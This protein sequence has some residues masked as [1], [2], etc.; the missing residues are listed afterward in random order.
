MHYVFVRRIIYVDAFDDFFN[1]IQ[2]IERANRNELFTIC[3]TLLTNNWNVNW[4][5]NFENDFI[6]IDR[7]VMTR[8]FECWNCLRRQLISY[9]NEKFDVV[10]SFFVDVS[11]NFACNV[12]VVEIVI[13]NST[14]FVVDNIVILFRAMFNSKSNVVNNFFE[15]NV[16][17]N[18]SFMSIDIRNVINEIFDD[19]DTMFVFDRFFNNDEFF[20]N[21][22]SID[23]ERIEIYDVVVKFARNEIMNREQKFDLY[24]QRI[25]RW[26]QICVSC[27][28]DRDEM[29]KK[30]HEH[31]LQSRHRKILNQLRRNVKLKNFIDC[32]N[33]DHMQ[34]ICS[35]RK[36]KNDCMQSWLTWHVAWTIY[37][38]D[39]HIEHFI[40]FSLNESNFATILQN[41]RIWHYCHWLKQ[42]NELFDQSIFNMKRLFYYWMNRLE[43]RCR[44]S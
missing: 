42:K 14:S 16:F 39:E 10:C 13:K 17:V 19:F 22:F 30:S 44:Q 41:V 40:I 6:Y 5:V 8:F 1:Y 27:F 36:Q 15:F 31:C 3:V 35:R 25:V 24:E 4:N 2:K 34:I 37:Y 43:N 7:D 9:L 38:F 20:D 28:F 11:F 26:K 12:Y 21:E 18:N 23:N 32:F 33:C 29:T